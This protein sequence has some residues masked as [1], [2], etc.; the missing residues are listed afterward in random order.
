MYPTVR[1]RK[2]RRVHVSVL[3][4]RRA[5]LS[6]FVHRTDD[7]T[8]PKTQVVASAPA[9]TVAR[10]R[11]RACAER[12]FRAFSAVGR[13]LVVSDCADRVTVDGGEEPEG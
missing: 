1:E 12:D 8:A 4:R 9:P 13:R 3:G 2:R 7:V 10:G 6:L 11:G 5:C